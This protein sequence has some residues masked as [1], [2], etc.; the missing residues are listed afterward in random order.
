MFKKIYIFIVYIHKTENFQNSVLHSAFIDL[1]TYKNITF[2]LISSKVVAFCL[3]VA[4][5][6]LGLINTFSNLWP[7]NGESSHAN[8]VYRIIH[9]SRSV[10]RTEKMIPAKVSKRW[11]NNTENRCMIQDNRKDLSTIKTN[12]SWFYIAKLNVETRD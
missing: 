6:K 1:V 3:F 9:E 10:Q 8:I 5:Y 7:L 11:N 12:V 2:K 4:H